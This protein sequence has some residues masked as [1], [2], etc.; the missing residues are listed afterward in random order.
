MN[1]LSFRKLLISFSFIILTPI[2][3]FAAPGAPTNLNAT[4][5][6]SKDEVTVT[7]S[8]PVG[9]SS[10]F[11]YISQDP[12]APGCPAT[13][14]VFDVNLGTTFHH[15]TA[16][17]GRSYYYS[18]KSS[19]IFGNKGPCTSA[20]RGYKAMPVVNGVS[21]SA[22]SSS[23]LQVSWNQLSAASEYRLYY[24]LNC[25]GTSVDVTSNSKTVTGLNANTLYGFS[26]KAM[27]QNGL[28]GSATPCSTPASATTLP[29]TYSITGSLGTTGASMAITGGGSNA[30]CSVSGSNYTCSNITHLSDPKITPSKS[31]YVFTPTSRLFSNIAS[32][33][34]GDF[35]AAVVPLYTISGSILNAPS[36]STVLM[37]LN[38]STTGTLVNCSSSSN[39]TFSCGGIPK[40]TDVKI[41]PAGIVTFTPA[42]RVYDNVQ[43]NITG[44]TFSGPQTPTYTI[45]GTITLDGSPVN[46]IQVVASNQQTSQSLGTATT[47]SQ[48]VY[49]FASMPSGTKYVLTPQPTPTIVDYSPRTVTGTLTANVTHNF[50]GIRRVTTTPTYTISG[51]ITLGNGSPAS[52]IVVVGSVIGS[53]QAL[54]AST[55]D[56]QGNYALGSITAGTQYIVQPQISAQYVDFTPRSYTG[57]LVTNVTHD[58]IAIPAPVQSSF[59]ISGQVLLSGVALPGVQVS[60]SGASVSTN[61]SG[62]FTLTGLT[63]GDYTVSAALTGYVF[64]PSFTNPVTING[65]DRSGINFSASCASG[66]TNVSN[67]CVVQGTAPAIP[68][69]LTASDGTSEDFVELN[70]DTA[71]NAVTY[72]I[73][74][75]QFSGDRGSALGA[76]VSGTSSLDRS[77]VPGVHYFYSVKAINSWG[78][79]DFSNTDEGFRLDPSGIADCDGDGVSDAQEAIDGTGIC[80]P[81]S[82]QLHLKSPAYTKYNTF[83]TQWNY[84]ELIANGTKA[85]NAKVTVY[86]INGSVIGTKT[87]NLAASAQFDVDINAI[88]K[89]KDTYGIVKIDFNT[90]PGATLIGRMSNYRLNPDGTSYSFA[91]AKE[92]RNPTRG[93]TY[94]SGNA[95]DPQGRGYLVPNW[96]EII[97]LDST[98]R[99]FTYR[100]YNQ[101]GKRVKSMVVNVPARGERDIEAGHEEGPGVYLSEIIPH[102]G[103]AKYFSTVTRYSPNSTSG[104][105]AATYNFAIPL[106]GRAG[107]GG[108][109]FAAITNRVGSCWS[110]TNWV[111]V[112]N[113]REKNVTAKLTFR[114]DAGKTLGSTSEKIKPLSQKHFNASALLP[115]NVVGSVE[116]SGD[117]PG[118]LIAQSAVYF[119]DCQVNA[120]QSSYASAARIPG[121]DVM[122]GSVNT[123]LGMTNFL[124]MIGTNGSTSDFDI[125]GMSFGEPLNPVSVQLSGRKTVVLNLNSESALDAKPNS[126]GTVIVR[127]PQAGQAVAEIIRLREVNGRVDFAMP[128]AVQ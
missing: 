76:P 63:N 105:E 55:T 72:Q 37:V 41:Y 62:N 122:A 89:K 7:W 128:T 114:D 81:G 87:V 77:A 4:D 99:K 12:N 127:S 110:Q 118:S 124:S 59:S 9:A 93:N 116:I 1:T 69:N 46:S 73:Y 58:F 125:T 38:Y 85:I 64:T 29:P 11:I 101:E 90:E 78:Q 103:A 66:Y 30:S 74:R 36:N 27:G 98:S 15:V 86:N 43:S 70:W 33:K 119:H 5:G 126:Y 82:F 100:L 107:N 45:S 121:Q 6:S 24:S 83:L 31:G 16:T 65:A 42:F 106:D 56:S 10:S 19:D 17:P 75:S 28:L 92:L 95:I 79:S 21:A 25:A 54:G 49:H 111:E 68:L 47:N 3:A 23:S 8:N 50:A 97:N 48:G 67:R 2:F 13:A 40:G 14:S 108:R 109:Q 88:V 113:V 53:G 57:T 80:D 32:N 39:N 44:V 117:A 91:F 123:F 120:L 71:T 96:T 52:G 34:T 104:S 94:A 51:K 22:L 102:D 26:V 20:N 84:L 35:T 112:I 61:N 60:T 115:K 18:L